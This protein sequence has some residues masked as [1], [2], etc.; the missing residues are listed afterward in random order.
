[1]KD[2]IIGRAFGIGIVAGLAG[3]AAEVAWISTYAAVTNGEAAA[4]ARAVTDTVGIGAQS[5]AAAGVAIH[6]TI[7][8]LLGIAVASALRHLH[9]TRLYAAT[10]SVLALVWAVNF[11]VMLPLINPAFVGIVPVGVSFASKLL[12][13]LAAAVS[14]QLA[15]SGGAALARA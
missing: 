3:G 2:G 5:P 10:T 11:M 8:A 15:Q 9:G 13:G 4:V 7:A 12:F 1:M 6:M 14:L